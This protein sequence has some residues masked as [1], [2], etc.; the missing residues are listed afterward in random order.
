MATRAEVLT[1]IEEA[2]RGI[3]ALLNNDLELAKSLLSAKSD[4]FHT[5]ALGITAFLAASLSREEEEVKKA[6]ETLVKAENM[7]SAEMNAK[8]PKGEV[9]VFPAGLEFKLL[10]GDAVIGQALIAILSESYTQFA[11][12]LWKLNAAYKT[13]SSTFKVVFPE[14]VSEQETLHDI[15]T[16]LNAHYLKQTT[17]SSLGVPEPSSGGGF[18]SSWGRKKGSAVANLRHASSSSALASISS[19]SS[20]SAIPPSASEPPTTVPSASPS[21]TDLAQQ[22]DGKLSLGDEGTFPEPLWKDDPLTTMII[23]SAS[24]GSGLFGLIFSMMPPRMIKLVSWFGFTSASRPVALK[25]LTVAASTGNDV[26]GYFASLTLCTF[27]GFILLMG[28]WQAQESYILSQYASVLGRVHA[29]FPQGTLWQLNRAKLARMQRKPDEAIEIIQAALAKGS[30][31][32]EADSLLVFELSW[33][34]LSQ[35]RYIDCADSFE[36]MNELNTWSPSTYVAITAGALADAYNSSPDQRTPELGDRIEKTF[37]KLPSLFLAKRIFGEKPVT[38]TFISR[39]YEA[40]KQKLARW[41]A[42]GRVKPDA[43]LWEVVKISNALELGLLWAT[44]GNRS[45]VFGSE[46][47]IAHLSSF[48]PPPRFS[49]TNAPPTTPSSPPLSR[50]AT[51]TSSMSRSRTSTGNSS[52]FTADDLDSTDEIAIRDLLLGVLYASFH[53]DLPSL[54]TAQQFLSA[55]MDDG[56][57]SLITEESWTVPFARWNLA[58]VL[59]KEADLL[60]KNLGT[61]AADEVKRKEIWKTRLDKAERLLEAVFGLGEYDFKTRLESRVLMLKDEIAKKRHL[62]GL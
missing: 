20:V 18:F 37:D 1:Q 13:F 28:G 16:K 44:V 30:T 10:G 22:V 40:H 15:F 21:V 47:H 17:S 52:R 19:T 53:E 34:Y 43:K 58:V 50:T 4:P 54:A 11:K 35:A 59:C 25:L 8:R 61:S 57:A 39:R 36:R 38:E 55:V 14:G 7:A 60:E 32:R 26:H 12:A 6:T 23:S 48:S 42:T 3:E 5:L 56:A 24:L 46:K 31:F 2:S 9:Q 49:P 62:V 27:Y 51:S 29:R 45:P 41:I 33:L